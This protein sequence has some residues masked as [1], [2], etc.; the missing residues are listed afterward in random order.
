MTN[1]NIISI[2]VAGLPIAE[3][4]LDSSVATVGVT[5]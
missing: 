5:Q 4:L 2:K 1:M 3:F